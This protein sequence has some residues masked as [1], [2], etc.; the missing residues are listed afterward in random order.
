MADVIAQ[1]VI[2]RQPPGLIGFLGIKNL[3]RGNPQQLSELLQGCWELAPWYA[4]SALET[5]SQTIAAPV[6]GAQS[7]GNFTVPPGEYWL[8]RDFTLTCA[9]LGAAA[10][11]QMVPTIIPVSNVGHSP[12]GLPS[13]RATVGLQ[14]TAYMERQPT[15]MVGASGFGVIVTEIATG[16]SAITG[17]ISFTRFS[18]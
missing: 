8:L 9:T 13:G 14:A 18:L 17:Q 16:G 7:F 10:I 6:L 15:V 12:V 2:N 11:M 4:A 1:P 5:I 3:G